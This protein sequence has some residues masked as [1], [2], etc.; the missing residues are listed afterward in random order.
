MVKLTEEVLLLQSVD[1]S[2]VDSSALSSSFSSCAN[3]GDQNSNEQSEVNSPLACL[4]KINC[5]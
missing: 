1:S 3:D 2:S 5:W 4:R